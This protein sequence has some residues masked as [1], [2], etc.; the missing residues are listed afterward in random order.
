MFRR[1]SAVIVLFAAAAMLTACVAHQPL[2]AAQSQ[3]LRKIA[4]VPV[5]PEILYFKVSNVGFI[6]NSERIY[7]VRS[8][9]INEVIAQFIQQE[10][11]THHDVV[12]LAAPAETKLNDAFFMPVEE[13]NTARII[14]ALPPHDPVD[15]YLVV[16]RNYAMFGGSGVNK[17]PQGA[18]NLI[19]VQERP[20][21]FSLSAPSPYRVLTALDFML[22]DATSGATLSQTT[23]F[24]LAFAGTPDMPNTIAFNTDMPGSDNGMESGAYED[25]WRI[26]RAMLEKVSIAALGKLGLA[27]SR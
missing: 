20:L 26:Y 1:L 18:L 4:I 11:A 23:S 2:T 5:A 3:R 25:R 13:L 21:S 19:Y 8:W 14:K 12:V 27:R 16:G 15:A 22:I 6:G 10:L 7:S 17:G 24:E 9:R